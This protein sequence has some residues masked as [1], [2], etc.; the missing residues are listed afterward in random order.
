MV[1]Y[2]SPLRVPHSNNRRFVNVQQREQHHRG[3]DVA[4][5]MPS[6]SNNDPCSMPPG[7]SSANSGTTLHEQYYG[8]YN[9][10]EWNGASPVWTT[11]QYYAHEQ[12][13]PAYNLAMAMAMT[14]QQQ[15]S[16]QVARYNHQ[17]VTLASFMPTSQHVEPTTAHAAPL[18]AQ[19]D[20]AKV[21]TATM[22]TTQLQGSSSGQGGIPALSTSLYPAVTPKTPI[23]AP[24]NPSAGYR[25]LESS[26]QENTSS[27]LPASSPT[28]F[29]MEGP[30]PV[31]VSTCTLEGTTVDGVNDS[32]YDASN[33]EKTTT[34]KSTRRQ[35]KYT[36]T[37]QQ[38]EERNFRMRAS[39]A[40]K[41]QR[42]MQILCTPKENRT[43]GEERELQAFE[44]QKTKK[45]LRGKERHQ[46]Q[47][48]VLARILAKP[49]K[50]WTEAEKQF[51]DKVE[52]VKRRKNAA[53]RER[54]K[55]LREAKEQKE[56]ERVDSI[57]AKPQ[58]EWTEGDC[59]NVMS[60]LLA[61]SS[62]DTVTDAPTPDI[63]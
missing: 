10:G 12:Q 61:L 17:D 11:P 47:K 22:N 40:T 44:S 21:S 54:R 52:A 63:V 20:N 32:E 15:V 62:D 36:L 24:W 1:F 50:E 55:R 39:S 26:Q 57:A 41:R 45:N 35:K 60:T 2:C 5:T 43:E 9:S 14:S 53:D 34:S 42:I 48:A 13:V 18:V 38:V 37:P 49:E 27:R 7:S 46:E 31:S 29:T 28:P 16:H 25:N 56:K 19:G 8:S 33:N 30:H 58:E 3:I 6:H 23:A 4:R 59:V 51:V